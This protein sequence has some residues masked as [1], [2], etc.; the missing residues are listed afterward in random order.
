MLFVGIVLF[1][2][3][4]AAIARALSVYLFSLHEKRC[5]MRQLPFVR[6]WEKGA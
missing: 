6:C 4:L 2:E 5:K 3:Q 1:V